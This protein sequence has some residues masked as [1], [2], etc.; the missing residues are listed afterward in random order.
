[1]TYRCA[2]CGR[3]MAA[4]AVTV[5]Q[6]A[7]GPSCARRAGLIELGRKRAG[8]VRLFASMKPTREDDKTMDLFAE[9]AA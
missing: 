1:M 4:P 2:L 9:V 7:V 5:G 6:L 3:S 8:F